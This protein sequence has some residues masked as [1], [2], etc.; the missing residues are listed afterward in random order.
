M[1][2]FLS[3]LILTSMMLHCASR[4]GFLSY[5]Y[6]M[7]E[8]IA[9]TMGVI[10]EIP[11]AICSSH[12]DFNKGI[13]V[14]ISGEHQPVPPVLAQAQEI[15]LFYQG[16]YVMMVPEG[17]HLARLITPYAFGSDNSE[18]SSIFQPPRV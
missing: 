16:A 17:V 12:Y 2:R 8:S 9:Y 18:L 7:R 13:T 3:A 5:V 14:H 10:E 4:I 6:E 15:I 11:I 1:K